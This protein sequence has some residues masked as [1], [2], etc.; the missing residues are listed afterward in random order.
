MLAQESEEIS[1]A[2]EVTAVLL[3]CALIGGAVLIT[4]TVQLTK[5]HNSL[6]LPERQRRAAVL[7]IEE[8]MRQNPSIEKQPDPPQYRASK[9]G[10][11]M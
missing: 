7:K 2:V 9:S 1:Q 5:R 4:L 8:E 11:F 3:V 6:S 10:M